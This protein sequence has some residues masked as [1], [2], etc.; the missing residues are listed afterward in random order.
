MS[1]NTSDPV[2]LQSVDQVRQALRSRSMG[3]PDW[4]GAAR[5]QAFEIFQQLPI[6]NRQRTPLRSRRLDAIPYLTSRD[7][8][9]IPEMYRFGNPEGGHVTSSGGHVQSLMLAPEWARAGVLLLSL[10]KA[11]TLVPHLVEPYLGS[12]QADDEDR[13]TAANRAFW[14]DGVFLYVPRGVE[15][16][17]PITAIHWVGSECLGVMPRTLVVAEDRA[18][19]HLIETYLG[20]SDD[21]HRLLFSGV[22]EVIARDGAQV[23]LSS[24]QQLPPGTEAFLRRRGRAGQDA[25]IHWNTGEFG[26][27]LS[28]SGHHTHLV[29]S[30]SETQS[31]TVFFGAKNQHQ[32]Y[33]GG[34]T[35]TGPHTKSDIL[36]RGVM[37]D[38][39]RSIFTGVSLIQKGAVKTDARQKEQILMLS[40]ESRADAI[41]SLLIED[42]DVFA[43]HAAS[44]GPI[45]ATALYYLQSRGIPEAEAVRLIVQGFLEPIMAHISLDA[46]RETVRAAVERKLG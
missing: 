31:A 36:A 6:P 1:V 32:D 23:T 16:T 45:D 43:A 24:L 17:P 28:V 41:P 44:A 26:A 2:N 10:K 38:R 46:V 35:H 11:L 29:G 21:E 33:T 39:A 15:I 13:Y 19:V 40:S 18:R 20:A 8:N 30:G 9:P 4:H 7:P 37:K 27:S 34:V 3:E 22:V 12:V 25:R 5:S 42:N 14:Q